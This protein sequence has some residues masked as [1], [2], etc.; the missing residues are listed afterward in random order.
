MDVFLCMKKYLTSL[1]FLLIV[2]PM[3][4]QKHIL[5]TGNFK[6]ICFPAGD[7]T[8][9][10]VKELPDSI[11]QYALICI[12]SN[13]ETMLDQDDLIKLQNFLAQG[14]GLY[15]GSENWP[16]KAESDQ[17]TEHFFAKQ[18]WGNFINSNAVL[19]KD[20]LIKNEDSIPAGTTTVAF[21]LDYRLHVEAWVD[22]EPLIL[23]GQ[24]FGGRLILDGGYSRFY[25][26]VEPISTEKIFLDFI[27]F[28]LPQ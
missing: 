3:F 24:L 27:D 6:K 1:L 4:S 22:D 8:V 17:I 25:C 20:A 2:L 28:L 26:S 13:A 19:D 12:F 9:E 23:S 5:V 21:P 15:L 16:F 10:Y 11:E 18:S 14:K 7:F